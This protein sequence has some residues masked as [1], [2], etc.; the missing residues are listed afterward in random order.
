[1]L[2]KL[3]VFIA[4]VS[5]C[6]VSLFLL[7]CGNSSSHPSGTLYVLTQGSNGFG[8]NVTSYAM[9]FNSGNLSLINSNASTCPTAASIDNPEPCGLPLDILLDPAGANAFVLNQGAPPCP[10]CTTPTNDPLAPSIYPYTVNS[11]G[12]LS[13]PGTAVT[14]SCPTVNESPCNYSDTAIAMTRDATGQFLFVIDFGTYPTP[15][16]PTPSGANPSC[17]H[18]PTGPTDVCPSISVF[19]MSSTTLTLASGSP[20][21][22]SKIP[23]ALSAIS[24]TPPGSTT[25][26]ELLF[27]TNNSDICTQNCAPPSPHSDNTVSVYSVSSLG[28]LTETI[29]SPYVIAAIDPISVMAVYTNPAGEN[30]GGLFVYVGNQDTNGGHIYPFEVCTVQSDLCS[31]TQVSE[32][33]MFPLA[34]CSQPSCNIPPTTVGKNPIAMLVDPTNSFL[35]VLNEGSNQVY[36]FGINGGAGTL[37]PLNPPN[38]STGAQPVAMAMHP[39]LNNTGQL[40]YTSNSGA[41]NITGWTLSTTTGAMSNPITVITPAPPSGMTAH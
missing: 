4:L 7:N 17:P 29:N 6:A 21:Y 27:V 38:L 18:S 10:T 2:K 37:R 8:N 25:A 19:A 33:F 13:N 31:A 24:F 28:A 22:L 5:L 1:M 34:T 23:S 12:S 16:Y 3:S 14:W 35:Y 9:D 26:Q 32:S 20:M 15:G 41:D 40:L 39:S 30:S 11:D 36:G